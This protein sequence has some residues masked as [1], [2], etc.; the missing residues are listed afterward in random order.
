MSYIFAEVAA[1]EGAP[2]LLLLHGTGGHVE[3][4]AR[5]IPVYARHFHVVAFDFRWHGCS[6]TSGFVPEILP[7]LVEHVRGVARTLGFAR[8]HVEGQSLGGWVAMR[9]AIDHAREVNKDRK[10]VV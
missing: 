5:N 1:P 8:Y 2:L 9:L 10:S 3:N 4:Y 7:Q 6:D